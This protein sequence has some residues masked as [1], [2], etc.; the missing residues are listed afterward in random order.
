MGSAWGLS[1]PEMLLLALLFLGLLGRSNLLA[2]SA[3]ILLC[4]RC[5]NLDSL[6]LP[7]LEQRG[8]EIGLLL[9]MLHILSP[10]A[11]DKLTTEDLK[12]LI[13]GKGFFALVSG[14]L[15]TKLNGDGLN[16]M[17]TSP[18]IIFGMTVGT[19]LGILVLRGTPCGPVMA[20]AVTA[21]FIQ[22][23]SLLKF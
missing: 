6:L 8:L 18:E 4:V 9:L 1:L 17:N 21:V 7:L 20:A 19:V 16:L 13:S 3:C 12:H 14:A 2:T 23:S 11:T 10:I 22:L 5:F 15:A